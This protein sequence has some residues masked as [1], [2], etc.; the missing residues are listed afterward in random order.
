MAATG[1]ASGCVAFEVNNS[2]TLLNSSNAVFPNIAADL[3]LDGYFD[4]GLPFFMGRP[5]Y[6]GI[7]NTSSSIGSGTYWAY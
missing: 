7:D 3:G 4:W 1:G 6:V 2:F 5:V